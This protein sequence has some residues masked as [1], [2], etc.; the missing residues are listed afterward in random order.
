MR[1]LLR[2]VALLLLALV[3]LQLFFVLR[4]ALMAV[5]DPQSTTFQ[6]SEMWRITQERGQLRWRQQW[7]DYSGLPEAIETRR[8]RGGG[9]QLQPA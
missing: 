3:A 8:D 6:R 7:V 5:F 1:A 2:W 4:I 9:R